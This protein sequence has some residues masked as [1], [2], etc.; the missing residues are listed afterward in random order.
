MEGQWK[1]EEDKFE[2]KIST[3]T[4]YTLTPPKGQSLKTAIG[5]IITVSGGKDSVLVL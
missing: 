1:K 2:R 4:Y 3:A 5:D